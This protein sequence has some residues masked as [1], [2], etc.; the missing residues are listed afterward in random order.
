MPGRWTSASER[1]TGIKS[2]VR[3]SGTKKRFVFRS[4]IYHHEE[5]KL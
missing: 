1:K 3:I 2:G 5:I 4:I